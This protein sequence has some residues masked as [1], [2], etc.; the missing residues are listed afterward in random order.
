[1]SLSPNPDLCFSEHTWALRT[2]KRKKGKFDEMGVHSLSAFNFP[3]QSV[4]RIQIRWGREAF[5]TNRC[6]PGFAAAACSGGNLL[7]WDGKWL[8]KA[9]EGFVLPEATELPSPAEWFS[10]HTG[11]EPNLNRESAFFLVSKS[12]FLYTSSCAG[13][14]WE[15]HYSFIKEIIVLIIKGEC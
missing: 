14:C 13:A 12:T 15:E 8:G 6:T 1:M 7:G 5:R 10:V 2:Y 11:H 3:S 4:S 9:T